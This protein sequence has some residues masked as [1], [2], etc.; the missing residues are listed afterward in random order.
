MRFRLPADDL[1]RGATYRRLWLS[2]LASS[3]GAQI[4]L[5]ALPL[6]AVVLLRASPSQMGTLTAMEILPFVLFSLP[7]GVWLDRVR[8]LRVYIGGELALAAASISVPLA[9]WAGILTIHGLF[10]VGFV[11]GAVNTTAGSASQI[12]LTQIVTRDR[13][14]EA[15][16]RNALANSGAQVAGPGLAGGLIT[17]LGGPLTLLFDAALLL[18][19]TVIL[20]GIRIE[21]KPARAPGRFWSDLRSGLGFVWSSRVLTSLGFF[22]ATWQIFYN[23]SVVVT[24]LFATRGLDLSGQDVGIS[25]ICLGAGTVA[26]SLVNGRI[27]RL[28]GPG[29]CLTAGF[30]LC[31]CSWLMLSAAPRG[32]IGNALFG[33]SLALLGMGEMLIF[34]NFIALRQSLTPAPLLGR[35]TSTMR[36]LILIPAMP[37]ALVGG[38]LGEHAGLRA[39]LGFAGAGAALLTLAAWRS[40][41]LR[42]L[43]GLPDPDPLDGGLTTELTGP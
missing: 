5:L 43:R 15:N 38:W 21:E 12:V 3:F 34:I 23:A 4:T 14:I 32:I 27:G 9:W 19:S 39:A 13:L 28:I 37:G 41:T 16:A 8:K 6:T 10:A 42:G 18:L 29:S 7:S 2:I 35:M 33:C 31:A 20:A 26:G 25:Y 24:I 22:V 36:W 1:L 11:I 30:G 17:L 40:P